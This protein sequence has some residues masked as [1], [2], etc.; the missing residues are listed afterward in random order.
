[1]KEL[2]YGFEDS[3]KDSHCMSINIKQKGKE[4]LLG[5]QIFISNESMGLISPIEYLNKKSFVYTVETK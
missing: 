3:L 5:S 2:E 1:M 4:S